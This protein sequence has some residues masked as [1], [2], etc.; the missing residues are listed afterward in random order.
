MLHI[1]TLLHLL[2]CL[3]VLQIEYMTLLVLYDSKNC[4]RFAVTEYLEFPKHEIHRISL[5]VFDFQL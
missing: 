3:H 4:I 5:V 2:M 1:I